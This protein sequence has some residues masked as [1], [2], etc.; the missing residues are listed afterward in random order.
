MK[1]L[2]S[3]YSQK[4]P[5]DKPN[6][7][8]YPYWDQVVK[9]LKQKLPEIEIVQV[10]VKEEKVIEGVDSVA[11]NYSQ[12]DLL[13]LAKTCNA[14]LSVDNFFQHFCT[15][16]KIPNGIVLFGQSDPSHFGY[17]TNINLLKD[18]KY[19]RK[20]Q[21]LFWWHESVT[22]RADAFVGPEVVV[23]TLVRVLNID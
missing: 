18:K 3:P 5:V 16:Y 9:L 2:I 14:W 21:F 20:E 22:Y 19:F 13:E 12:K 4:L 10:G 7:K 6:P 11:H 15:Y 8:N 23:K 17:P 1:I